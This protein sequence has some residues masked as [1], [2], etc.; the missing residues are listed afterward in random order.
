MNNITGELTNWLETLP[1]SKETGKK[2]TKKAR[3]VLNRNEKVQS[4]KEDLYVLLL[5]MLATGSS[6]D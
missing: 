4:F 2:S 3:N 1:M 5:N 6:L